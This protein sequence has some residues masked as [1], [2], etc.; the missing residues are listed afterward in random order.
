VAQTGKAVTE[1]SRQVVQSAA[2]GMQRLATMPLS[3]GSSFWDA[4]F[5]MWV[6]QSRSLARLTDV[7]PSS[8]AEEVIPLAE[9]T[10]I[11][12]KHTVT[13]GTTKVRRFVVER[14]VEE[15]VEL[16]DEKVVVERRKPV[17]DAATGETLTEVTVEMIETSEVPFV[18]KDVKVREEV[19]VR[20]ERTRRVETVR[21]TV[22]R[23]EI[24]IAHSEE[25]ERTPRRQ[26]ALARAEK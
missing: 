25:N 2:E 13:S 16:Y 24:E 15:R 4:M 12:G 20:R 6:P 7:Q 18:A 8:R 26:R 11:V 21:G 17:T 5:G 23:D 10:L 3:T 9:E 22:R 14:P 19:V 1:S